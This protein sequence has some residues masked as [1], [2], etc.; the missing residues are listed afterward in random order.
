MVGPSASNVTRSPAVTRNKGKQ[1]AVRGSS[2]MNSDSQNP[3]PAVTRNKG[4]QKATRGRGGAARSRGGWRIFDFQND[5]NARLL[6]DK[7][8]SEHAKYLERMEEE[9]RKVAEEK[10]KAAE[11]RRAALELRKKTL[12]EKNKLAAENEKAR[13][14][15]EKEKMR[16]PK[17]P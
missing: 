6:R 4:K 14:E 7:A 5:Q 3:S 2:V 10:K 11:E 13:F 8:M 12:E 1:K 15:R 9:Q 17:R 16:G